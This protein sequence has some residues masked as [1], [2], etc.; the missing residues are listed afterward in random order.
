MPNSAHT[1]RL[2]GLAGVA[3]GAG[4][5]LAVGGIFGGYLAGPVGFCVGW[6]VVGI[7]A[8]CLYGVDAYSEERTSVESRNTEVAER[9]ARYGSSIQRYDG[10]LIEG[11]WQFQADV[12]RVLAELRSW[13]PRRYKEIRKHAREIRYDPAGVR[14]RYPDGA[15]AMAGLHNIIYFAIDSNSR[16]YEWFRHV[17]LHEAGHNV[18]YAIR[19]ED[20]SQESADAY[21]YMVEHE[22]SW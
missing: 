11:P 21:A 17:L 6:L 13:A 3:W 22:L 9:C 20:A 16:G 15:D 14:T 19:Q 4:V 8:A 12:Q 7:P 5:G 2:F 10:F 1:A 18:L